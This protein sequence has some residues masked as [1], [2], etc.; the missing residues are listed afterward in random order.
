MELFQP[1][2]TLLSKIVKLAGQLEP[3]KIELFVEEN[4][5]CLL[6]TLYEDLAQCES[7]LFSQNQVQQASADLVIF[8]RVPSDGITPVEK[9]EEDGIDTFFVHGKI[10]DSNELRSC[11]PEIYHHHRDHTPKLV[12]PVGERPLHVCF[13]RANE[14]NSEQETS[15]RQG[16]LNGAEKYIRENGEEAAVPYGKDFC[17]AVGSMILAEMDLKK[18]QNPA[19]ANHIPHYKYLV[20]W[21]KQTYYR[22]QIDDVLYDSKKL[23]SA[24]L[25]EGETILYFSITSKDLETVKQ[26][27][28]HGV[29]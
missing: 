29:K 9:R 5:H 3:K 8:K 17:A 21:V 18:K 20:N 10:V 6:R 13:L 22:G 14:F 16:I 12:G 28:K 1:A 7:T 26:L 4:V 19:L 2:W 27:L 25:Y 11:L 15:I 23:V 24:G